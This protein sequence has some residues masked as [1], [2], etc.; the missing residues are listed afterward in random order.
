M[1]I[2][3]ITSGL[4]TGGA[5]KTLTRLL[6]ELR[7]QKIDSE[8]ICLTGAGDVTNEL[9]KLGFT[10]K[11]LELCWSNFIPSCFSIFLSIRRSEVTLVQT[12]LYH[13][14]LLGGLI[15][16]LSSRKP[17]VWG[18]RNSR[19]EPA[20]LSIATRAVIM[21]CRILSNWIPHHIITCAVSAKYAHSKM[22]YPA[23][24]ISVVP[25]G[26]DTE[27]FTID[28]KC[29]KLQRSYYGFLEKEIV[30]GHVGRYDYN[31]DH[32]GFLDAISHC[33]RVQYLKILMCGTDV[34][35]DNACLMDRIRV[36]GLSSQVL[37]VGQQQNMNAIYQT[38]DLYVCSSLSEGFPNAV[39]EAM[40]CGVPCVV[41]D[42]G[43]A[44][45]IVGD[46]GLVVKVRDKFALAR[47]IDSSLQQMQ[48]SAWIDKKQ[49][50]RERIKNHFGL[51]KMAAEYAGIYKRL[52]K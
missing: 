40:A 49:A 44:A 41:T 19:L 46:T 23:R 12:W 16:R 38:M 26:V 5:E 4:K 28:T 6:K 3:F 34:D 15:T 11:T 36:L 20:S 43:D 30:I 50:V 45:T 25:N 29:R 31:K 14:D 9:T 39:A 8:V 1:F 10:V 47:A 37:C 24:R 21:L 48:G 2:L 32:L 42:V 52:L 7:E 35:E 51:Q 27:T 33:E 17:V 18:V 22:G 13:A